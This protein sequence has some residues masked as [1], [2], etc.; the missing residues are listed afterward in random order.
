VSG[1]VRVEMLSVGENR[2]CSWEKASF[3]PFGSPLL[4]VEV[5]CCSSEKRRLT[6]LLVFLV[7]FRD[8]YCSSFFSFCRVKLRMI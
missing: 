5:D 8:Y 1:C 7:L 6:N 4:T 3:C 2:D